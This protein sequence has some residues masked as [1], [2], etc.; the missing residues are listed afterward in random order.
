MV[1]DLGAYRGHILSVCS[2]QNPL[3]CVPQF[4]E[5]GPQDHL[6]EHASDFQPHW[7]GQLTQGGPIKIKTF[8]IWNWDLG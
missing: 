2:A 7:I 1:L 8:A 6:V 5:N 4:R 3:N